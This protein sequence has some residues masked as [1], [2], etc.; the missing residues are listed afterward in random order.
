MKKEIEEVSLLLKL[1]ESPCGL[2]KKC[3]AVVEVCFGCALAS[4]RASY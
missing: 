4:D 3:L 2:K 1:A